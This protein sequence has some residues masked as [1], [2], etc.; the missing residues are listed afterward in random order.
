[1]SSRDCPG[2]R[3]CVDGTCE[4][5]PD[6]GERDAGGVDGGG[7][8][9]APVG[10]DAGARDG[11]GCVPV[12]ASESVC[13]GSDD[14]CNGIIDDLDVAGDGIC[15]CL[16]IGILGGPGAN[17][18][19]S[20]QAWLTSRGTTVMR[21]GVDGTATVDAAFLAPF[22]ILVLDWLPREYTAAEAAAL[23]D[24]V[25]AGNG[26]MVMTGHDGG[27][28]RMRAGSL[29]VAI[30]AEYLP[31]LVN[32]PVTTFDPHP[33]TTGLASVTFAGGY[34]VATTAALGTGTSAIVARLPGGPAGIALERGTGRVYVWGDEWVEFDSEWS[35]MPMITQFW[36]NALG[37][38][39]PTNVCRT[40]F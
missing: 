24:F 29:L 25:D 5:R 35:T 18:S 20:F 28:D 39:A 16:A 34:H 19:S 17:P 9:D 4:P 6:A 7:G 8:V 37:W 30:G 21:V 40:L 15:D 38:L 32:G 13:D 23:R 26:V 3:I 31:G 14:D 33:L 22:D 12:G 1:M 27:A 10:R 11:G 2:E 36:I